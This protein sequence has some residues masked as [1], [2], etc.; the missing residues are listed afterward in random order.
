MSFELGLPEASA[1]APLS[2]RLAWVTA[3][4]LLFLMAA[5]AI[6][7]FFY[8]KRALSFDTFSVQLALITLARPDLPLALG[9][10]LAWYLTGTTIAIS[11]VHYVYRGLLWYQREGTGAG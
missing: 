6:F 3:A 8:L 7:G 11:G 5:L 10:Q 4:R 1:D 2:R 9:N